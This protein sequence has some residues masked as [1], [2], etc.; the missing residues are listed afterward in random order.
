[1]SLE[2]VIALR[3]LRREVERGNRLKEREIELLEMLVNAQKIN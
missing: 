3:K 2:V 1:M